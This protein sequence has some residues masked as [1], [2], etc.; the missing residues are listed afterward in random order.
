MKKG[1]KAWTEQEEL[2][3]ETLR[4]DECKTIKECAVILNRSF[5]SVEAMVVKLDLWRPS[6][7]LILLPALEK[8]HTLDGVAKQFKIK[9]YTVKKAKQELRKLGMELYTCPKLNL[10]TKNDPRH[11]S[12]KFRPKLMEK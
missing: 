3:L 9:K 4:I 12:R 6:K 5:R 2:L 11:K 8:P 7:Y 1:W 10:F